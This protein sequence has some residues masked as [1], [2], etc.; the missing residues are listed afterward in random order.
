MSIEH[1]QA[2][3]LEHY[4]F[5]WSELRL[6]IAALALFLGGVPP[7]LKLSTASLVANLL[8]L[9]W[10]VSGVASAY[11]LYRWYAVHGTLFGHKNRTDKLAFFVS[12]ITGINLGLAG[13]LSTNF[14]LSISNN[15]FILFIVGI[16]YLL[17]SLYL[18]RRW[19]A[20]GKKLF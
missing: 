20:H 5:V 15:R 6:L 16:L 1:T 10:I 18:Y 12:V 9:S 19:Q 3:K 2:A 8:T 7:V 13:L 4:S 17:T 11:L 14:G